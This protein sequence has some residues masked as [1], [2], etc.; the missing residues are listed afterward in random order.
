VRRERGGFG[1]GT[2]E[3]GGLGRAAAIDPRRRTRLSVV[4]ASPPPSAASSSSSPPPPPPPPPPRS[5]APSRESAS[6]A[7]HAAFTAP[8]SSR[9]LPFRCTFPRCHRERTNAAAASAASAG[10]SRRVFCF[11]AGVGDAGGDDGG[12]SAAAIVETRARP[13]LRRRRDCDFFRGLARAGLASR[14]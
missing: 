2:R 12:A 13:G 5:V 7:S 1:V 11:R 14:H 6:T 3:E 4:V 9:A 10:R 8:A